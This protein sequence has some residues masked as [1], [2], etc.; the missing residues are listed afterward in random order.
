MDALT[1]VEDLRGVGLSDIRGES[2]AARVLGDG[3]D[4]ALFD[5]AL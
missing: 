1:L 4:A 3:V 2:L 5:S